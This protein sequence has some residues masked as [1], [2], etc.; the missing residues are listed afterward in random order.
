MQK[1]INYCD[2]CGSKADKIAHLRINFH[3][4]VTIPP[5][6]QSTAEWES[7][8]NGA[9]WL[10][11]DLCPQCAAEIAGLFFDEPETVTVKE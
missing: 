9:M 3:E 11:A 5:M 7:T 4:Y 2:K 6:V 10:Q 8:C 1:I